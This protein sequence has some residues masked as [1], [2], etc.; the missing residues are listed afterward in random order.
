MSKL[1]Y[2]GHGSYRF[3]T[4][5]NRVIYVDPYAGDGYDLPA[6]LI[7][8]T[9]GHDDHNQLQLVAK[10]PDCRVITH[11]D[12]LAGGAHNSFDVSGITVEAV[13]AKNLMHNPKHCVGYIL[14]FDG[15]KI[16][17]SGD[18]SKTSQMSDFASRGLDCAIFCG[19]GKFNMGLK[20]AAECA[21][22]VGA[23]RNIIVHR[24]PGGL[25]DRAKAEKWDAP[26]KLI[27]EPGQEVSL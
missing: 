12:A 4:D 16:Y 14:G 5:D 1:Y 27:I 25:F 17:C 22:I 7:V 3:T 2:Q 21:R 19:D 8:V 15:L 20:E 13:E 24:K 11:E 18:T 26:N 10:K 9:H 6:D 23:K